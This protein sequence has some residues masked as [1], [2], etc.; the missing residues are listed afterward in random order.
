M[1]FTV[2]NSPGFVTDIVINFGSAT[3]TAAV[4]GSAFSITPV[5]FGDFTYTGN[6]S[7]SGN[8]ISVTINEADASI[9]ETCVYTLSGPKQ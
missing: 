4:S 2:T 9:P 1:S 3:L 6:G 5:S 7:I 8:T